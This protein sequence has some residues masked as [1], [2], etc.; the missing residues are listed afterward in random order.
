M[1]EVA[2]QWLFSFSIRSLRGC[3]FSLKTHTVQEKFI[4]KLV[5]SKVNLTRKTDIALIFSIRDSCDIGV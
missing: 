1:V 5:N 4:A 3:S 2:L